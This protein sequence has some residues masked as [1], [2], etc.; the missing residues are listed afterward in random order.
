MLLIQ[1]ARID[2]KLSCVATENG[3]ILSVTPGD[4]P[5]THAPADQVID[6]GGAHLFPGLIDIHTHG[7]MGIDTMDGEGLAALRAAYFA[8]GTTTVYPTT[9]TA[10]AA[11]IR[12]VLSGDISPKEGCA[13]VVGFH[14]EGPYVNP[15][16]AGAQDPAYIKDPD[17]GEFATFPNAAIVTIAP[18]LPGAL[19]FIKSTGACV[20]IGHT[21]ADYETARAAFRAGARQLTH[22][23]NAMPPLLHRAPGPIGAAIAEDG[24]AQVISDGL[25]LHE[26][27]VLALYRMF[28]ARRM[29]LISDSMRA[30]GMPDGQYMLGGLEITVQDGVAR[31]ADGALA[32]STT[33]LLGCVQKAIS[34]GIPPKDAFAM[35]SRTP[36]EMLGLLKGVIAPGY[37]AEFVLVDDAYNLIETFIFT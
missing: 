26:S 25:H 21:K 9:V 37:D 36:A 18:E 17:A 20:A 30:T 5:A 7:M 13:N 3:K 1:N 2:G 14:V 23:C 19:E 15:L 31:T 8:A 16:A 28:G 22:T 10:A 34:F 33:T 12:R 27:M 24:Y 35:A 32:G 4:A 29:I 6:A 11:D